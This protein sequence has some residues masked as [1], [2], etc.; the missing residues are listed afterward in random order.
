[1]DQSVVLGWLAAGDGYLLGGFVHR[2]R[3]LAQHLGAQRP[4]W[5]RV[6]YVSVGFLHGLGRGAVAHFGG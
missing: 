5:S 6:F 2:D 3:K 1:M 4:T